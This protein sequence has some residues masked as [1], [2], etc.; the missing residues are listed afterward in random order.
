MS[1]AVIFSAA[2]ASTFRF[3]VAPQDRRA[4]LGRNDAVDRE[5]LH[6]DA[7]PDRDAERAAAAALAADQTTIG[8]SSMH[9]LA[10]VEGDRLGDAALLRL[11][12]RIRRRRIDEDDDRPAELLGQPHDAQRLAIALRAR[13]AEVAVDLL[14]GVAALLVA[15]DR[16]RRAS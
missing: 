10:Q 14:L 16:D 13:I 5:L 6:Q 15:D 7:V 2:A 8:T 3:G 9:H 1:G 12:P 11:D 4:A